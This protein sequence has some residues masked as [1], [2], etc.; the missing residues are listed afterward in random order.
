MIKRI[1]KSIRVAVQVA[2][3]GFEKS[4]KWN[5][6]T[7]SILGYTDTLTE[8]P[9]RK[10]FER[11]RQLVDERFALVLIDIDNFKKINDTRGHLYGDIVLKRLAA[12]L[13]EYVQ[14]DG[15]VYRL[16]GDEFVLI[17]PKRKVKSVCNT[18]RNSVRR[19][20]SFTVSQGI[21]P[22]LGNGVSNRAIK[23]A[24]TALYESKNRGKD[25]ITTT[26]PAIIA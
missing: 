16:A 24:D 12:M 17:I 2:I 23:L 10:A 4:Y 25:R 9:N 7:D 6:S 14:P 5:E 18:I 21:V 19:E 20:D 26:I 1:A 13:C 15:K 3:L 11:D 8:I 22:G